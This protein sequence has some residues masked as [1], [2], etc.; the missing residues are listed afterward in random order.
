M[1]SGKN[2]A[3]INNNIYKNKIAAIKINDAI[4]ATK[5]KWK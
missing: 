2:V 3:A 5:Q 4:P 1:R